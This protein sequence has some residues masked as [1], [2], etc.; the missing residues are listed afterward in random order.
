MNNQRY[1]RFSQ[2]LHWITALAVI[3]AFAIEP[4]GFGRLMRH[5]GDPA[6]RLSIVLHET[7]GVSV[8]VLTGLRLLWMLV[9]PA[10]PR[11]AM[12]GWMHD[13]ARLAHAVLW[14]L[15][16]ALPA[17]AFLTLAGEGHS[18]TLVGGFR[19]DRM[20]AIDGLALARMVDWGEVHEFLGEAI[21]WIAGAH[22]AAAVFHH[23]VLKDGVLKSMLPG[24][25]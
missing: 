10:P 16:L 15:L 9:R 23:R 3:L 21:V 7:L 20:P 4:E 8:L 17:T 5:G 11:I 2:L 12:P 13:G 1:D 24:K 18:L 14:F 25:G 6:T 19:I 22:A